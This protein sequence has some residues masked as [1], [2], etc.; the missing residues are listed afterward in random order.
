MGKVSMK[1]CNARAKRPATP[2]K[3]VTASSRELAVHVYPRCR[4][5]EC[6]AKTIWTNPR[7]MLRASI[8]SSSVIA[9]PVVAVIRAEIQKGPHARCSVVW[10]GGYL[11]G[12][13]LRCC[14][15]A[16]LAA[17]VVLSQ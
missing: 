8:L 4:L 15:I 17:N 14:P 1:F 5:A 7:T 2:V 16:A 11:L 9:V 10:R 12:I 13:Y 3:A 6:E